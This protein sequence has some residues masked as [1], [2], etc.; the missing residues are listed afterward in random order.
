LLRRHP[1]SHRP[2]IRVAIPGRHHREARAAQGDIQVASNRHVFP[3]N[4][5][6]TVS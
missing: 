1:G 5:K 2:G 6:V 4:S 3:F